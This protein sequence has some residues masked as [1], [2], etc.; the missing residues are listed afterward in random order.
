M[1]YRSVYKCS[2]WG[3][4]EEREA[5]G[6]ELTVYVAVD[7]VRVGCLPFRAFKLSSASSHTTN[8]VDF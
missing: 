6:L 4:R 1:K 8:P 5:G 7:F 2:R 3:T